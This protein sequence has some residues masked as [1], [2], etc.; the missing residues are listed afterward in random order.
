MDGQ[1]G[2]H[3]PL[4]NQPG[5]DEIANRRLNPIHTVWYERLAAKGRNKPL[6]LKDLRQFLLEKEAPLGPQISEK[7]DSF[8]TLD[9]P[10]RRIAAC[11]IG[12]Y[13]N[14]LSAIIQVR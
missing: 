4:E 13:L 8:L 14:Q 3:L 7:F 9:P 5:W 11:I 6:L 12:G 1:Y 2:E 10:D